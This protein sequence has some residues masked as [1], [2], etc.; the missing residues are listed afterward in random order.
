VAHP[1]QQTHPSL[2]SKRDNVV[3]PAWPPT[4]MHL[5]AQD[6]R[7]KMGATRSNPQISHVLPWCCWCV[8]A[9]I[10][11]VF[12][13]RWAFIFLSRQVSLPSWLQF[14]LGHGMIH[15]FQATASSCLHSAAHVTSGPISS[16]LVEDTTTIWYEYKVFC[17]RRKSA[18]C[19]VPPFKVE[20]NNASFL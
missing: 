18:L 15:P 5:A 4:Y 8:V 9:S 6:E 7:P 16:Q 13:P 2:T 11:V 3:W 17:N 19:G 12:R 20:Y 1:S 10:I 14:D